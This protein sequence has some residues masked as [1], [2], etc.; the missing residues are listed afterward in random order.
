M[1]AVLIPNT[2]KHAPTLG[3]HEPNTNNP[4]FTRGHTQAHTIV[5]ST[6]GIKTQCLPITLD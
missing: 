3:T 2:E 1:H 5:C 4:I 6:A